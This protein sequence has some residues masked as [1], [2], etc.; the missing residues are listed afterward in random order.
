MRH[1]IFLMTGMVSMFSSFT[2]N[3]ERS[4]LPEIE[5]PVFIN[6]TVNNRPYALVAGGS[7]GIGYALA[8]ALAKRKYNLIL[9]ARH[10]DSLQSAKQKL[11]SQFGIHV[12]LLSN[13]LS[14]EQAADEISKWCFDRNIP[15]KMLCNVAG[16]GGVNDYLD[17]PLDT[18]RYMVNLNVASCMALTLRLL[19]LL[20]KNSPSYILNVA[21]MAGFAPIPQ[22]NLYAAT[23]SFVIFFSYALH[24]QLQEKNIS[25]SCLA[26]GPVFTKASVVR[27]TKES[28][29]W[30]GMKIQVPPARVGEVAIKKTLK[31]KLMIVPGTVAR[32]TS[33]VI[34]FLPKKTVASIYNRFGKKY[35]ALKSQ[36]QN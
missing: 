36:K 25:V 34:R 27:D 1:A 6:D 13:D 11:E 26:P 9:I 16:F 3:L 22:K 8:E 33:W 10:W 19:P 23:K 12:E 28:L 17:L 24:Y 7:K 32:L 2:Q 21:S 4:T 14:R 18:L 29:G 5:K 31:G 30:F 20:E 35:S 15:L